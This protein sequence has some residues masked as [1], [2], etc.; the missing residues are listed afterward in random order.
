MNYIQML[1]LHVKKSINFRH[2]SINETKFY[3]YST[4]CYVRNF[5]YTRFPIFQYLSLSL[6]ENFIRMRF[7]QEIK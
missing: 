3:Y 2:V 7:K 4:I 1:I 6:K 5:K